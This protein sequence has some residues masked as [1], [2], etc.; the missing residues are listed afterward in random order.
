MLFHQLGFQRCG[1]IK[2]QIVERY[3]AEKRKAADEVI[4]A[5]ATYRPFFEKKVKVID[6]STPLTRYTGNWMGAIQGFKP[7]ANIINTFFNKR[8]PAGCGRGARI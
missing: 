5:T 2:F 4:R 6:V 7:S 8:A 3:L 1:G